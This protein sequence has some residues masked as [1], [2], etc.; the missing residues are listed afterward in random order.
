MTL[1]ETRCDK[2]REKVFF[3]KPTREE[4]QRASRYTELAMSNIDI[5]GQQFI[6]CTFYDDVWEQ[7]IN[8]IKRSRGE[9]INCPALLRKQHCERCGNREGFGG[10][11]SFFFCLMMN[12]R[13]HETTRLRS[14]IFTRACTSI[15]SVKFCDRC[16]RSWWASFDLI[17]V[18]A[19]VFL[20][21]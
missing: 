8:W 6:N 5:N 3:V 11:I 12:L 7:I 19:G 15:R 2:E 4:Q 16:R 17:Y 10:L 14:T 20:I 1:N 13:C 9:I 18:L 21:E